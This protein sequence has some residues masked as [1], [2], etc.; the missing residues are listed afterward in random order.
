MIDILK[1]LL[2]VVAW[3]IIVFLIFTL[4]TPIIYWLISGQSFSNKGIKILDNL[5]DVLLNEQTN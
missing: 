2:L 4:I 5:E 1:R 3:T